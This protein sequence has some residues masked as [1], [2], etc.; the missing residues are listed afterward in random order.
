MPFQV[1][2]RDRREYALMGQEKVEAAIEAAYAMT[3][4]A[5]ASHISGSIAH[6]AHHG[7]EADPFKPHGQCKA[8]S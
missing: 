1:C 7:L 6:V 5:T 2:G 3:T 4:A 8:P